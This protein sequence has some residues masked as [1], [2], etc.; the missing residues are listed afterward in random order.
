MDDLIKIIA[1]MPAFNEEKYIA[2]MIIGCKKYVDKV[3]V[4][5]DGSKDATVEIAEA[6]GAIVIKHPENSG[7]GAALRT[8]FKTAQEMKVDAMV[9]IDSDGQ[10]NPNEIPKL[11][12]PLNDGADL[13]VGSRFL[14]NNGKNIPRYRKIGM[15][16]LDTV[17][18]IAGGVNVSDSQS[19]FR[20][21][22]KK[23]IERI[24]INRDGMSAGSEILCQMK[25][26]DLKFKE[27]EIYCNYN[28]EETSS[29]NPINHGVKILIQIFRDLELR[30]PLYY[31]T[32]PGMVFGGVG[33]VM[34]L[35]FLRSFYLG[36]HL[37]F[38]PTLL[39]ITL[40]LIGVFMIFTGI[41]LHS[42]SG[43]INDLKKVLR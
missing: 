22:G 23:A 37:L 16:V 6:M 7:Y 36:G 19:G 41:I 20:A 38:G 35:S 14:N 8:I 39:M 29:Q 11:L 25:E 13:V 21:Y 5:D 1:A 3:I 28:L 42:M 43:L 33:I 31:I 12:A 9:I 32:L 17:T 40:T 34:G 18:N 30:K 27:V 15:K 10:H 4:V 26:N 24:R 2:K